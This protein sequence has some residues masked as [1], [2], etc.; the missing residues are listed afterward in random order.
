MRD[1]NFRFLKLATVW[2][3]MARVNSTGLWYTQAQRTPVSSYFFTGCSPPLST[4]GHYHTSS[5]ISVLLLALLKGFN[6]F[7]QPTKIERQA[8]KTLLPLLSI[9][10]WDCFLEKYFRSNIVL[11][12]YLTVDAAH[13]GVLSSFWSI[14]FLTEKMARMVLMIIL[15]PMIS[16]GLCAWMTIF[17]YYLRLEEKEWAR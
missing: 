5:L 14:S 3:T 6:I 15:F 11:L 10:C 4:S 7:L 1:S 12:V 2:S 9:Q 8:Q 16:Y 17:G 13:I